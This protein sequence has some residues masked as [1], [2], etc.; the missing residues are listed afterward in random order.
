[1]SWCLRSAKPILPPEG[2]K[3]RR[4]DANLHLRKTVTTSAHQI[5]AA[6]T[7]AEV[8]AHAAAQGAPIFAGPTPKQELRTNVGRWRGSR[9]PFGLVA[10]KASSESSI[11]I[12]VQPDV[13]A[14][15]EVL[16]CRRC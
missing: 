4:H 6:L 16:S 14:S 9:S 15:A 7:S 11:P 5:S 1:M 8:L 12:E 13:S 3:L 2:G 10:L